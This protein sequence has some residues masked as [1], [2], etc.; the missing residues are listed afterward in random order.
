LGNPV[1]KEALGCTAYDYEKIIALAD[2]MMKR[3]RQGI[4][5]QVVQMEDGLDYWIIVATREYFR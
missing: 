2:R 4:R 1:V 3:N 5:G